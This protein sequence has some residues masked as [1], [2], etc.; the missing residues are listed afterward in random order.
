MLSILS[1]A[2]RDYE[3]DIVEIG[4]GNGHNTIEFLK[5]ADKYNRMV[6]VIDPF[7]EDWAMMPK[8]YRY[9]YIEFENRVS[10]YKH[11]LFLHK[12]SSLCSTSD[13]LC[14]RTNMAF[15][16]I[17]G[18][19]YKGAVLNDLRI[20]SRAKVIVVDDMDRESGESQV[21]QAIG[22]FMQ[23]NGD[24]NLTIKNRWAIIT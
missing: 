7:E 17:D 19:Q 22:T 13:D 10:E 4:A 3:G 11:R 20:L 6:V 2:L 5:L 8:G 15:A 9:P 24:R 23:T 21:P 12:R 18:L 16:Y 1:K 14:Q